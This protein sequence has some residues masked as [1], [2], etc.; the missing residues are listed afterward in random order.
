MR[1]ETTKPERDQR[2]TEMHTPV[3]HDYEGKL[4]TAGR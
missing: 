4:V 3:K 1:E 2:K